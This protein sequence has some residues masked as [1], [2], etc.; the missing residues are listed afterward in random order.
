[1]NTLY[2]SLQRSLGL[3]LLVLEQ[4]VEAVDLL[5]GLEQSA[6]QPLYAS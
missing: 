4:R 1:M 2:L 6:K 3:G 5:V